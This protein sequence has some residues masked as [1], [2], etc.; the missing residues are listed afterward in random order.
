M[1]EIK[2]SRRM[3]TST[4]KNVTIT[5]VLNTNKQNSSDNSR[6]GNNINI[7]ERHH[8]LQNEFLFIA[9]IFIPI[10]LTIKFRKLDLW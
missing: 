5:S 9:F 6:I 1:N 7:K 4:S 10:I 2:Q 3:N 8:Q